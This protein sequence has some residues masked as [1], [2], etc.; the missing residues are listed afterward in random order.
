MVTI[1]QSTAIVGASGIENSRG[2]VQSGGPTAANTV[3]QIEGFSV[4]THV[5][6][7]GGF[8]Q[9]NNVR[10][11]EGVDGSTTVPTPDVV[12]TTATAK[13]V[14]FP[15][16]LSRSKF[17]QAVIGTTETFERDF[18]RSPFFFSPHE[19]DPNTIRDISVAQQFL[20]FTSTTIRS[21]ESLRATPRDVPIISVKG[22]KV[23]DEAFAATDILINGSFEAGN[24]AGWETETGTGGTV[25]VRT[26]SNVGGGIVG[27]LTPDDGTYWAYLSKNDSGGDS[28]YIKQNIVLPQKYESTLISN[29]S[30]NAVFDAIA[31]QSRNQLSVVFYNDEVPVFHLRYKFGVQGTP[32]APADLPVLTPIDVGVSATSNEI[33]NYSRVF[34]QDSRLADFDFNEVEVW[35]ITDSS[36]GTDTDTLVD[37]FQLTLNIPPDHFLSTSSFAHVLTNHPTASGLSFTI[38]GSDDIN[39]IDQTGPFFDET[40]PLSGTRFNPTTGFV[41]FHVKDAA[42]DLDQGN[43]D[44][45]ID[46]LQVVDAGS[47]ITGSV[48]PSATKQV[49]SD[50]DIQYEFTRFQ[51]FTPQSTVV[52]SGELTDLADPVS[53]QTITDYSF[54]ILGSGSLDATISG[55]P[56]G[57][58]PTIIPTDP[59]DLDTQISPNTNLLWS[60]TDD[61]SGVD[62]AS[63]KLLINGATKIENDVASA[64]SFSRTANSQRGFDYVYNPLGAFTFGET[65]TG[66]IEASDRD[67]NSSSLDYEFTITPDDT[68]EIKDFFLA[69]NQSTLIT[70]GTEISVCVEDLTHGV[71]VSGTEFLINGTVPSG[72]VV[73]T[74]GAGPDKVT[75][76]VPAAGI[77]DFRSDINVFVHAENNFPG[78]FPVVKEELFVLRPGY[79]VNWWNRST[80]T[81]EGAEEVFPYITSIQVLAE[82]KNFA[83]NFNDASLF[84]RFLTENQQHADLGASIVSNIKTADLPASVSSLNTIFEYGKEIVL[85]LEVADLE[86]NQLSFTHTFTIEPKPE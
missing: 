21:F 58:P 81:S 5:D 79:D 65:V 6:S 27:G 10:Q 17:F 13:F 28:A 73:T 59:E 39:Q 52:V 8:S 64:G 32:T 77:V 80:D 36:I 42:S 57:T 53:N 76:S 66:T 83:K 70:S 34:S 19:T 2:M 38:S 33:L 46:G 47:T 9:T 22:S 68:L 15:A 3:S 82:V 61:A 37:A 63:V 18:D 20:V 23:D 86:G 31:P 71:N 12:E 4:T 78:A 11:F 24:F 40:V 43:V 41:S 85:E 56:D 51:D 14:V 44:V 1:V 62:P 26:D 48:W 60:I 54:T 84:Y 50:R 25:E 75:Y 29:L 16:S 67:G 30:W 55:A 69:E 74:S 35:W 72:L 7:F 49:I 45:W